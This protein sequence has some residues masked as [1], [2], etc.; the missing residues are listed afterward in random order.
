MGDNVDIYL[1][2]HEFD[3]CG[4]TCNYVEKILDTLP[5]AQAYINEIVLLSKC[6]RKRYKIEKRIVRDKVPISLCGVHACKEQSIIRK[7]KHNQ[8]H[9]FYIPICN[10]HFEKRKKYIEEFRCKGSTYISDIARENIKKELEE[11]DG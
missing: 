2:M 8:G 3:A 6:E 9:Y 1:V 10:L 4:S 5:K 7:F 11:R